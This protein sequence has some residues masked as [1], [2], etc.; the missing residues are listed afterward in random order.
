[1]KSFVVASFEGRL[2]NDPR[3]NY[4]A[5][6]IRTDKLV[7]LLQMLKYEWPGKESYRDEVTFV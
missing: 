7:G 6:E 3:A 5:A 1:M 4:R 2:T